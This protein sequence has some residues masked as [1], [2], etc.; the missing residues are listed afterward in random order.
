MGGAKEKEPRGGFP[1]GGFLG[2]G[3]RKFSGWPHWGE[4][5]GHPAAQA[6]DP[7]TQ[8]GPR[9]ATGEKPCHGTP[10]PGAS[11]GNVG[12]MSA[13]GMGHQR[14]PEGAHSRGGS[15]ELGHFRPQTVTKAGPRTMFSGAPVLG[16][17][18]ATDTTRGA[19]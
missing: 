5:A 1:P 13:Q 17:F 10:G 7:G 14:A 19:R 3:R 8:F 2:W 12:A 15:Q 11:Q 6:G 4:L 18:Q 9:A 16:P